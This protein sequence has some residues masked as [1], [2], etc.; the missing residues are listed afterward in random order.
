MDKKLTGLIAAPHTPFRADGSINFGVIAQQAQALVEGRVTAAFVCGTTGEGLSLT[1]AER[2]QV[3]EHWIKAAPPE[4]KVIVHAGHTSIAD[5]K[6]LAA[7]APDGG[8]NVSL[9]VYPSPGS[10]P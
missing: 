10:L 8:N 4:L 2:Q 9:S 1:T 3:V 5:C 7:H 6:A